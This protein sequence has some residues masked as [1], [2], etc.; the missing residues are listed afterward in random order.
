MLDAI[1]ELTIK[2]KINRGALR[3]RGSSYTPAPIA[4]GSD[5]PQEGTTLATQVVPTLENPAKKYAELFRKC[6]VNNN[7][8]CNFQYSSI[9]CTLRYKN[10]LEFECPFDKKHIKNAYAVFRLECGDNI[11][12]FIK[13]LKNHKGRLPDFDGETPL[14]FSRSSS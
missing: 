1:Q 6:L 10:V 2:F 7:S 9:G 3:P 5:T 8:D 4:S 14:P 11:T 13:Y 12:S